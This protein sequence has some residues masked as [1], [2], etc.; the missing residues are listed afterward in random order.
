[1][2]LM[3]KSALPQTN[4]EDWHIVS[5]NNL[6]HIGQTEESSKEKCNTDDCKTSAD[7]QV[8]CICVL[9]DTKDKKNTKLKA[10]QSFSYVC[11]EHLVASSNEAIN[12]LTSANL[13]SG[14]IDES[15]DVIDKQKLVSRIEYAEKLLVLGFK[16]LEEKRPT[17]AL[18]LKLSNQERQE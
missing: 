8:S 1:M 12:N 9:P 16:V 7:F 3:A 5:F 11:A 6:I 4:S 14:E 15:I 17:V 13:F 2:I 18:N 10:F